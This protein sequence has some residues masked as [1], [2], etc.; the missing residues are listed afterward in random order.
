MISMLLMVIHCRRRP[1]WWR[2]V[3]YAGTKLLYQPLPQPVV[4]I[5]PVTD[6]L[7]RLALVPYG[8]TGTIPYDW[9]DLAR[10]YPKGVCD[11]QGTPGSGSK[12]FYISSWAM[13]WPSDHP[14]GSGQQPG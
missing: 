5:V 6:I 12:L 14:R 10:F 2:E 1:D 3:A 7:G 9:R 4:Y 8:E 11:R 13:I